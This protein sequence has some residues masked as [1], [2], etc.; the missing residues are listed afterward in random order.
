MFL[1]L[2]VYEDAGSVNLINNVYVVTPMSLDIY[3]PIINQAHT[4]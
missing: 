3:V 1:S 4:H 2:L